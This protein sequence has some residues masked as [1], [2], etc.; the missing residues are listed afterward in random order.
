MEMLTGNGQLALA[1]QESSICVD[2]LVRL[3]S[4]KHHRISNYS[5]FGSL[6]T[7]SRLL[8]NDD[9]CRA[10]ADADALPL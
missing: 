1:L 5:V 8:Q 7:P 10:H 2:E 4:W 6:S 9:V 3:N